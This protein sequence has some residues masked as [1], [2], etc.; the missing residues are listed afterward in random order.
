[1]LWA[2]H[3]SPSK[4]SAN[5]GG[6]QCIEYFSVQAVRDPTLLTALFYWNDP[7]LDKTTSARP[8]R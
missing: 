6:G 2:A 8:C 5:G 1:M 4:N 3:F 7:Q